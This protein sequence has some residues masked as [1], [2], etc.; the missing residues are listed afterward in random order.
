MKLNTSPS[1]DIVLKRTFN[2]SE[3]FANCESPGD[4]WPRRP[5]R[6]ISID[7]ATGKRPRFCF[8]EHGEGFVHRVCCFVTIIRVV[9]CG[10]STSAAT[11]AMQTMRHPFRRGFAEP[12]GNTFSIQMFT[13]SAQ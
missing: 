1:N 10:G 12:E 13:V 7:P 11:L 6:D 8:K 4:V 9:I 2:N 5:F 3:S